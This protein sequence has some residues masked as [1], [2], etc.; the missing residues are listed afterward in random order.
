MPEINSKRNK[1]NKKS[2]P[3]KKH[4]KAT[5]KKKK[6]LVTGAGLSWGSTEK[7][8]EKKKYSRKQMYIVIGVIFLIFLF[9]L[10]AFVDDRPEWQKQAAKKEAERRKNETLKQQKERETRNAALASYNYAHLLNSTSLSVS[11][12]QMQSGDDERLMI[13]AF[14]D[15]TRDES[16]GNV[17]KIR[18]FKKIDGIAK[19]I[20]KHKL[21]KRYEEED[22]PRFVLFDCGSSEDGA[23]ENVCKQIIGDNIPNILIFRPLSQ[24]RTLPNDLKS[25]RDII[26]YLYNLMQPAVKYLDELIEAEDFV[27]DDSELH[28]LLFSKNTNIN[29][30]KIYDEISDSLRDYGYF[31]R[32]R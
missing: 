16:G 2:A 32:T 12:Q 8:K 1:T 14:D 19:R 20:G 13:V 5:N 6:G 24:P 11:L 27:S 3:K 15:S 30:I 18:L 4:K 21:F 22:I 28:C 10:W 17:Y 9:I 26:T 7:I 29:V 23:S 31:G 25:D